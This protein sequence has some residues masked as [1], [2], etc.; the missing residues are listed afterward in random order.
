MAKEKKIDDEL[1]SEL[2]NKTKFLDL[3][4]TT[5]EMVKVHAWVLARRFAY[6]SIN[7]PDNDLIE[8]N[9]YLGVDRNTTGHI[10]VA[11]NPETGIR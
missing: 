6:V 4:T 11:G 8:P 3:L 2:E 7:I 5:D 9:G 1:D 10:A